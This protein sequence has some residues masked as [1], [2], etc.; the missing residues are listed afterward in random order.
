R[1]GAGEHGHRAIARGPEPGGTRSRRGRPGAD[2]RQHQSSGQAVGGEP[3]DLPRNDR[4][5][6]GEREGFS[7]MNARWRLS[8]LIIVG[9]LA[10][11]IGGCTQ[12]PAVAKQRH[13]DK[14]KGYYAKQQ[15]NEAIIEV[16]NALQIDPKFAPALHLIGR[17]YAAKAWHF[18]AARELRRAVDLEPTNL[19]AHVDLGRAYIK[20]EAWDDVLQEA[21]FVAAT[22]SGNG[23]AMYL[24]AAA[25]NA[26]DRRQDALTAIDNALAAGQALPEVHTVRGNILAG[27]DRFGEAEQA[28]RAALA[29]NAKFAAA[30]LGL[31]D[32]LRR[33]QRPDEA[34]RLL[35]QAK[36]DDPTKASVRLALSAMYSANGK[37][38]EAL[39]EVNALPK[40]SWT[41]RIAL[42]I[43]QLS[44]QT[45]HFPEAVTALR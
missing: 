5:A 1:R 34:R 16:K 33:Q 2:P 32:V 12:N 3:S 31:A 15:Y 25:L 18:D 41:P 37:F 7:L 27:L 17:A 10:V 38:E 30:T 14:A 36:A 28:Y 23:A 13:L 45:G 29:Q 21:T 4:Q 35:D 8:A 9:C 40:Q 43:G 19:E 39:K 42:V 22:D 6:P 20:L 11:L 44:V 24:R 26:K